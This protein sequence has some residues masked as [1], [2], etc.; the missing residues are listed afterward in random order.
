[1][2]RRIVVLKSRVGSHPIKD[3]ALSQLSF[4]NFDS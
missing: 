3:K 4:S 1:M 2:V